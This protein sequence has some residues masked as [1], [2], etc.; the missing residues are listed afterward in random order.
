MNK[1]IRRASVA[2][3]LTL[4]SLINC[5]SLA[6][7]IRPEPLQTLGSADFTLNNEFLLSTDTELTG[8]SPQE[9][10]A[11]TA[12]NAGQL[13][14]AIA[15]ARTAIHAQPGSAAAHE[16]LGAALALSGELEAGLKA[17]QTAVS[18]NPDQ[19]SAWTKIGDVLL[20]DNRVDEAQRAFEQAVAI[21]PERP[22][23]HQRLGLIAEYRGNDKVAIRHFELG[24]RYT[25][26]DYLGTKINLARLYNKYGRF[27]AA[28]NLLQPVM[29]DDTTNVVAHLVF[30]TSLLGLGQPDAAAREFERVN[31]LDPGSTRALLSRGIAYRDLGELEKSRTALQQ[32]TELKPAWSTGY[33]QLAETLLAQGEAKQSIAMFERASE[34]SP[35]P[36]GIAP[37]IAEA[38][39][40]EGNTGEAL[41]IYTT[42]ATADNA[43]AT[44]WERLGTLRQQQGDMAG[45]EQAFVQLTQAFPDYAAGYWRLGSLFGLT[46]QYDKASATYRAG[47]ERAPNNT[48]LLKGLSVSQARTGDS[49]ALKTAEQLL[50]LTPDNLENRFFLASLL[51]D[52]KEYD[53][54]T[55]LY[56][57]ILQSDP[58]HVAALNN[59]AVLLGEQNHFEESVSFARR[60]HA[61]APNEP[62]VADTLGWA[63]IQAGQI[64]QGRQVLEEATSPAVSYAPLYYHLAVAQHRM[65][66]T[67]AARTNLEQALSIST[68]FAEADQ[69]RKLLNSLSPQQ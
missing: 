17:L 47:L 45:A 10:A 61:L 43:P 27:Q 24:V 20:A 69:A 62:I 12:L 4:S 18:L 42:L 39:I 50:A 59:L 66:D 19:S 64:A 36:A 34:L 38:H 6:V 1:V 44:V 11:L 26:P 16:I 46:R 23:A 8:L 51:D 28:A 60:A 40:I 57:E 9:R 49:Q 53:R 30:G 63:L 14:K 65:Q 2:A 5:H 67:Q 29:A 25:P 31:A 13:A 58:E 56:K 22:R 41:A 3:I 37:R 15:Q 68:T 52:A 35:N 7:T 32:L 21:H 55:Q 54:A 48:R 33:Y